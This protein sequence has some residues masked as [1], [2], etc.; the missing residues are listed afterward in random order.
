MEEFHIPLSDEDLLAECEIFT[1]RSS[2]RGG[3][4]VNKTESVVRLVHRPSGLAVTC[5]RERSQYLNRKACLKTLRFRLEKLNR[6]KATTYSYQSPLGCKTKEAE[7]KRENRDQEGFKKKTAGGGV[8][9][10][11]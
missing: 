9:K 2:G 8:R 3:Q 1:F 7:V 5:R 6:K 4:H 11:P 10:G